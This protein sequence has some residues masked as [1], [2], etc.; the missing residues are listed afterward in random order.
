MKKKQMTQIRILISSVLILFLFSNSFAYTEEELEMLFNPPKDKKAIAPKSA[1]YTPYYTWRFHRNGL[2]WNTINNNGIIGNFFGVSDPEIGRTAAEY[3]YPRYSRIKHGLTTALWVGGVIGNDTLVSTALDVDYRGW[4]TRWQPEF[5]PEEYPD[6]DFTTVEKEFAIEFGSLL[7]RSEVV[8]EATYTDTFRYDPFVPYNNYDQRYHKPLDIKVTQTSYSWSYKYA[9]DFIIVNYRIHNIGRNHIKDTYVGLFHRGANY[10]INEM[11]LRMD[12]QE[13]YI[14]S[15]VHEFEELGKEPLNIAW[16]C[17]KGGHPI[18][19]FWHPESS[20]NVLGIAPLALPKSATRRNFNWWVRGFDESWGPR[21]KGTNEAPLRLF[22]GELGAPRGDA[23]KY[24]MMSHPELDYTGY[25]SAIGHY[26]DNWMPPHQ[27]AELYA[28]GHFVNYVTSYGPFDLAP[29]EAEDI[30]VVYAIGEKIH[31]DP[32]AIRDLFDP[33]RPQDFIAQLD[34][35][36]LIT[37]IRWAKRIYDNPGVDTDGDGDSGKYFIYFDSTTEESLQVYYE[38]DGIPDFRGATPPPAPPLRFETEDGRIIVKWNG[39][40]VENYFDSFSLLRDFEGYRVHLARSKEHNDIVLL[41]S[42]D[43]E[44]YSRWKWNKRKNIYELT[45][46]PFTLDSLKTLYGADFEP[47][48]YNRAEPLNISENYYF[49]TK[50]DYNQS[51]LLD[52]GLIHKVYPDAVQDTSD[53][54]EDGRMRYYEYRYIIEDLLPTIPYYVA[55]TAFDFG[56]PAKSLE[57]L[58]SSPYAN[59]FEVFAV[60]QKDEHILK[61]NKLNVYVYP[62]PYIADG[63]YAA[64]GLENRFQNLS[65]DRSRVIYF[66]NLPPVCIIKIFSLDGDLIKEIAHDKPVGSGTSSI[67]QFDLI[68]RNRQVIESGLYY[69]TVE[70][71][72]GNQVGKL[73]IIK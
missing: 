20:R 32:T 68:S 16:T 52:Q 42:Y 26:R 46:I 50:V 56:H 65:I 19:S 38:G 47:L 59:M 25:H 9:E 24:Y 53:V 10:F 6:G 61:D 58:E 69:W 17:D 5:W 62:N 40:D 73:V 15:V 35:D 12:E 55:V 49:F 30:V 4:W 1:S 39:R 37:N 36:D 3:M 14:D 13:G 2:L 18:G 43:L 29:N 11:P 63:R 67:E 60:N 72:F 71:E 27:D 57:P 66:A 34:F 8:F 23:N 70:S 22:F 41:T 54:D 21:I 51:D 7:S 48:E 44:D 33:Y 28:D 45:E 31:T 64:S